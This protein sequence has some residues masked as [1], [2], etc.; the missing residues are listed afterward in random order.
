MLTT[1]LPTGEEPRKGFESIMDQSTKDP[2]EIIIDCVIVSQVAP[3]EVSE[4]EALRSKA[5]DIF[6]DHSGLARK[7]LSFNYET[8]I[9]PEGKTASDKVLFRAYK[10]KR[11]IGY[12]LV[13][14]GWPSPTEWTIQHLVIDPEMRLKGVGSSIVAKIEKYAKSA[15]VS[16]TSIIAIPLEKKGSNFWDYNGYNNETHRQEIR[17]GGLDREVVVYKKE[18]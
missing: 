9:W 13:I 3:L 17:I 7:P 2:E 5:F 4:I 11:L 12:A 1:P 18:L 15:K 14:I 8:S 10:R 16:A 6:T